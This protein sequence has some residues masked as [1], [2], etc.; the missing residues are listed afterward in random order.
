MTPSFD[1]PKTP[2]PSGRARAH[3][4]KNSAPRSSKQHQHPTPLVEEESD[5]DDSEIIGKKSKANKLN[6]LTLKSSAVSNSSS[7]R[8]QNRYNNHSN[9]YVVVDN[10]STTHFSKK[11]NNHDQV[12]FKNHKEA[13]FTSSSSSAAMQH[14]QQFYNNALGVSDSD[15]MSKE[16]QKFFRFSVFNSERKSK[17]VKSTKQKLLSINSKKN[18]HHNNNVDENEGSNNNLR[19][20]TNNLA[21]TNNT[22]TTSLSLVVGHDKYKFES[23]SDS[24]NERVNDCDIS[25][26]ISKKSREKLTNLANNKKSSSS[27]K[28]C[29]Q[30]Q[31][32]QHSRQRVS[33]TKS[34]Q[35]KLKE[36]LKKA[37]N[38]SSEDDSMS[39]C[40]TSDEDDNE[41]SSDSSSSSTSSD[42]ASSSSGASSSDSNN[43]S[44]SSV[45]N[46]RTSKNN[47]LHNKTEAINTMNVFACI[48]SRELSNQAE[49]AFCWNSMSLVKNPDESLF[50]AQAKI[51]T[52]FGTSTSSSSNK[53]DD[54]VW[55]FAA[56]AKK[57]VN[58]FTTNSDSDS[59]KTKRSS[60]KLHNEATSM[61]AAT[62]KLSKHKMANE[63]FARNR[64]T[65]TLMRNNIIMSSDDDAKQNLSP[66]KMF[67]K[68]VNY[69]KFDNHKL[70]NKK[71]TMDPHTDETRQ[72]NNDDDNHMKADSHSKNELSQS[73]YLNS[74]NNQFDLGKSSYS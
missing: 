17:L 57:S 55:G 37:H 73:P 69:K 27:S 8:P 46:S 23:S 19:A 43:S 25:N 56:E 64:R 61:L 65:T 30:Q 66:S 3:P 50:K 14:Q 10:N 18:H 12:L 52:P 7:S 49:K 47:S 22:S 24:E 29:L 16:K 15:R 71:L 63:Y 48:N 54:N 59:H 2:K 32:P 41:S 72:I 26:K 42:T 51:A 67:R 6:L 11:S 53:R 35:Q 4:A 5:N 62:K 21:I 1:S 74:K 13:H 68:A 36:K 34:R 45:N 28:D 39:S 58:I 9:S 38:L 40:C 60:S 20:S 70:N 31:Q 33:Y 44:S